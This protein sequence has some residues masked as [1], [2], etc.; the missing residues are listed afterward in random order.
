MRP[1]QFLLMALLIGAAWLYF[2]RLRSLLRDRVIVIALAL[3]GAYF[4]LFPDRAT[5]V[6]ER[7][8][9]GRGVDLVFYVFALGTV[10][11]VILLVSRLMRLESQ[12]E[13]L[14]RDLALARARPPEP[15]RRA[16]PP[17]SRKL[18][19]ALGTRPAAGK[20]FDASTGGPART[21]AGLDR[22]QAALPAKRA[23]PRRISRQRKAS[24]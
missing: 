21:A 12:I 10:F 5:W 22:R 2:S 19:P 1:I 4:I 24:Q 18:R 6:A 3:L 13:A 20:A 14:A 23:V 17:A 15:S 8:G 11:A 16:S 9:V 7:V